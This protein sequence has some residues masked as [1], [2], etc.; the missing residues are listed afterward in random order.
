ILELDHFGYTVELRA[1]PELGPS[2]EFIE[3]F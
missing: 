2:E 1:E 3:R